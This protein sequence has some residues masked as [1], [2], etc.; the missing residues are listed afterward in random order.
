M[1]I[2]FNLVFWHIFCPTEKTNNTL[3]EIPKRKAL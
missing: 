1:Y 2:N 3:N